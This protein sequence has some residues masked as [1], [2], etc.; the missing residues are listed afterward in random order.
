MSDLGLYE[1]VLFAKVFYLHDTFEDSSH[2]FV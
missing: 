1:G 2:N